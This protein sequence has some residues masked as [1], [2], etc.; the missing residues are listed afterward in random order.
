MMGLY[1]GREIRGPLRQTIAKS[2]ERAWDQA[3]R[4]G[5]EGIQRVLNKKKGVRLAVAQAT[6]VEAHSRDANAR[7]RLRRV[8]DAR[9][10]GAVATGAM[11][12]VPNWN[13]QG[14]FFERSPDGERFQAKEVVLV[15]GVESAQWNNRLVRIHGPLHKKKHAGKVSVQLLENGTH[16]AVHVGKLRKV[17]DEVFQSLH[18]VDQKLLQR[19][20]TRQVPLRRAAA[21]EAEAQATDAAEAPGVPLTLEQAMAIGKKM[22]YRV[23]AKDDGSLL[24]ERIDEPVLSTAPVTPAQTEATSVLEYAT[25]K[26]GALW[27]AEKE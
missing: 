19:L 18:A 15:D 16:G 26:L 8:L 3:E 24:M 17:T 9:E 7:S 21:A 2:N 4:D 10:A 6:D 22:G 25:A 1:G 14:T 5:V 13:A 23:D 20:G 27:S 12:A 11:E